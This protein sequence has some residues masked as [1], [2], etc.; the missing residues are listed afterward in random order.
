[1]DPNSADLKFLETIRRCAPLVITD[2]DG[3]AYAVADSIP[4]EIHEA[5]GQ[6]NLTVAWVEVGE[7]LNVPVENWVSCREKLIVGLMKR[8]T[9]RSLELSKVGPSTA[10]LDLAPTLSPWSAVLDPEYGGAILVGAQNGHPTLRGRFINTSRLCGLDTEGAWART[11]TRWYRLGD[12][13]SRRELCSLLYGRL[14]LA[15]ALMLT[16]SEVQAYIKA[17][18]IS[19]GLSDA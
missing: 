16:L 2:T 15:D 12:N 5:I 6:L 3:A 13:A 11:S 9:R 1:M 8:M 18:Q 17:D 14:G 19:A 7:R 10:E 4:P